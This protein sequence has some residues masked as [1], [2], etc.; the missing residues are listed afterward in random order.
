MK[1]LVYVM[2]L[3]VAFLLC[4]CTTG[5]MVLS[6]NNYENTME[7]V[8]ADI[9]S[10]GYNQVAEERTEEVKMLPGRV[11][12][13]NTEGEVS[14]ATQ[15]MDSERV[16]IDSY[17]F[18]DDDGNEILFKTAVKPQADYIRTAEFVGCE[19]T[20]VKDYEKLC[21]SN[22]VLKRELA[23][24]SPDKEIKKISYGK[25]FGVTVLVGFGVLLLCGILS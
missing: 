11:I 1:K 4:S 3:G 10:Y 23:N 5:Q 18:R 22:S 16:R 15:T 9:R 24:M 25:T 7:R 19:T 20:K 14:G 12:V 13:H 2:G 17:L 6:K 21:G 8:K